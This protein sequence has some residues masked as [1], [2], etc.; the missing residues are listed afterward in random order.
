MR[1][2]E[3]PAETVQAVRVMMPITKEDVMSNINLELSNVLNELAD[4]FKGQTQAQYS[5][6][7]L[8]KRIETEAFP[9]AYKIGGETWTKVN[10]IWYSSQM[11]DK[12]MVALALEMLATLLFLMEKGLPAK[13]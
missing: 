4:A 6:A 9:L 12:S 3:R 13:L 5:T 8:S 10:T 1:A 11:A 7:E 2:G